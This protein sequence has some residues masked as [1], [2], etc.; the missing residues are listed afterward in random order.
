MPCHPLTIPPEI[1]IIVPSEVPAQDYTQKLKNQLLF[2]FLKTILKMQRKEKE[3]N[4]KLPC[5][6]HES[7]AKFRFSI[8]GLSIIYFLICNI[9]GSQAAPDSLW[10]WSCLCLLVVVTGFAFFFFFPVLLLHVFAYRFSDCIA[11]F[12]IIKMETTKKHCSRQDGC[13]LVV[14][15]RGFF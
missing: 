6:E 4:T 2:L 3:F 11:I 9:L 12:E 8:I 5:L 13:H 14:N 1:T 10:Q 15:N 7:E